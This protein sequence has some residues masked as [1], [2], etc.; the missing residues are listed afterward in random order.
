MMAETDYTKWPREALID[1]IEELESIYYPTKSRVE[2]LREVFPIIRSE[3]IVLHTLTSHPDRV[4]LKTT[5]IELLYPN[6]ADRDGMDSHG[7][8]CVEQT[9][10]VYISRLRKAMKPFGVTITNVWCRGYTL[11]R[12]DAAK[13]NSYLEPLEKK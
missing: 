13:I 11:S 9:L 12:A 5:L 8:L 6:P 3:A 7:Q 10:R 2:H 1:R 4:V